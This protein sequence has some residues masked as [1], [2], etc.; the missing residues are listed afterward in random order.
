[1]SRRIAAAV[2]A[3]ALVAGGIAIRNRQENAPRR[4]PPAEVSPYDVF[5]DDDNV[6]VL[7]DSELAAVCER[8]ER[9]VSTTRVEPAWTT[10]DRL[11]GGGALGADA[12]LTFRPLD[13]MAAPPAAAGPLGPAALVGRSPLVLAG[14]PAAVTAV[15]AACRDPRVLLSCAGMAA[16]VS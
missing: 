4:S 15:K 7:C 2:L 5:D 16:D 1:M 11:G 6:S 12:W 13:E 3:V 9:F 8:L 10:A 14:P